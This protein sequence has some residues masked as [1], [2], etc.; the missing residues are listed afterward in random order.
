LALAGCSAQSLSP[1]QRAD[2]GSQISQTLQPSNGSVVNPQFAIIKWNPTSI[3]LA[4]GGP[5]VATTLKYTHGDTV[6]VH[7]DDEC[8]YRVDF[9]LHPGPSQHHVE[10]DEYDFYAYS[11]KSGQPS[12][13]C[14][15]H[16]LLKDVGGKVLAESTL[17]VTIVYPW[18]H[19]HGG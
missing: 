13:H 16:A 4:D 12:F 6:V 14:N 19:S 9:D 3:K 1:T 18:N 11:G 10:T 17:T 2:A 5:Y 15:V 7:Y 8:N